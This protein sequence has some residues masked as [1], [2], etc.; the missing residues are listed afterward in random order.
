MCGGSVD[1]DRKAMIREYKETPRPMGIF[2]I[3]N[4]ANG[5][6]FIGSSSNVP[7]ILN[8]H[9]SELKLGSHRNPEL[10]KEW[11]EFGPEMFEFT[12]LEILDQ[13]KVV[14]SNPAEDLRVLEE[15]WLEKLKPYGER[16]YNREKKPKL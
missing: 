5:K 8:R 6:V 1:M 2:Q 16:G 9:Q 13:S 10:L 11:R 4:K 14:S 7:A 12:V 3:R 15:L